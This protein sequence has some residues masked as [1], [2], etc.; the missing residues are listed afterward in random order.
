V[1]FAKP[2]PQRLSL[3]PSGYENFPPKISLEPTPLSASPKPTPSSSPP[4]RLRTIVELPRSLRAVIKSSPKPPWSSPSTRR[5]LPKPKPVMPST[6][7]AMLFAS[8]QQHHPPQVHDV[9]H[10]RCPRACNAIVLPEPATPSTCVV[11]GPTAS[12]SSLNP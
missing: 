4:R 5:H 12:S 11:P 6:K 3:T 1:A 2:N 9:S 10:L 8:P 7:R